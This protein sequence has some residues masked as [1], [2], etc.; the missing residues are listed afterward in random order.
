MYFNLCICFFTQY[1][2]RDYNRIK[3][4]CAITAAIKHYKSIVNK[5]KKKQDAIVFLVKTK[6]NSIEVL[7]SKA[8]TD[9]YI[10]M[11]KLFY[12]I[13]FQKSMTK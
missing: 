9:L 7:I 12:Y 5:K 13:I 10:S 1:C 8:L 3:N 11:M 6:L 2:Y 4:L